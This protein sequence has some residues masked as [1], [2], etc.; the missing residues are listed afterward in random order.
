MRDFSSSPRRAAGGRAAGVLLVAGGL[1]L[2]LSLAG[3]AKA[4]SEHRR[5]A[6]RLVDERS[7][8]RGVQTRL[9]SLEGTR[10]PERSRTLQ[11]ILTL[12]APP[13]R[14]FQDL[15]KALPPDVRLTSVGLDYGNRLDVDL[16]VVARTASSYDVFLARLEDGGL[17]ENIVPGEENRD[18]EVMARVQATYRAVAP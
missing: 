15:A 9:L 16:Q 6:L 10:N 1:A 13:P 5:A 12:E 7:G 11:A 4:W 3:L 18:G 2:L 17:F 14:V 8:L